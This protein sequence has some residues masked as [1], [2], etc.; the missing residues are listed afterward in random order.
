MKIDEIINNITEGRRIFE[1]VPSA[2]RPCWGG[3]LLA[4]FREAMGEALPVPMAGLQEI[5]DDPTRW[6][7]AYDQ[8][9]KIR[10]FGREHDCALQN[11]L[12]L[13][14]KIAKVTFNATDPPARF[15][16]NSG[17]FIPK[18]CLLAARE[19]DETWDLA[20]LSALVM[21]DG[22]RDDTENIATPKAFRGWRRVD[23]I[24][25]YDWDPIGIC[26]NFSCRD[27]YEGYVTGVLLAATSAKNTVD[28]IADHLRH[29]EEQEMGI[30]ATSA[31]IKRRH[32][33]AQKICRS[34][35]AG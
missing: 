33:A 2:V 32:A 15:D 4:R 28:D 14:E 11:F 21:F 34:V 18:L 13:A 30:D 7:E 26:D 16:D 12:L 35:A 8:F 17:W 5:C 10:C 9:Q 19:R 31:N 20:F 23:E 3:L 24:L 22:R 27:E 1:T 6:N 29:V 25:F